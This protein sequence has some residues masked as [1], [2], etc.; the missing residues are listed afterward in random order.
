MGE[1][2]Q[3]VR[4]R[5]LYYQDRYCT[6][7]D[8]VP[9]YEFC[10]RC[11]RRLIRVLAPRPVAKVLTYGIAINPEIVTANV[12][13]C[14]IGD[15]TKRASEAAVVSNGDLSSALRQAVLKAGEVLGLTGETMPY[16]PQESF[17]CSAGGRVRE[18]VNAYGAV[19]ALPSGKEG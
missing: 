13:I 4:E 2:T 17:C 3:V 9:G 6:C 16:I 18:L 15:E 12:E 10:S 7:E 5:V 14:L 11:G 19:L 1:A 8:P